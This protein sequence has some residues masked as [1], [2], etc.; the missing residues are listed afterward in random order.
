VRKYNLKRI[1]KELKISDIKEIEKML[2][3]KESTIR[4]R[5]RNA[6]FWLIT[7]PGTG[8]FLF[9]LG[10]WFASLNF[11]DVAAVTIYVSY[12]FLGF[13]LGFILM[14]PISRIEN[15]FKNNKT[16]I[17]IAY[18]LVTKILYI[19]VPIMIITLLF[20]L[21]PGEGAKSIRDAI[22][23]NYDYMTPVLI[24][25]AIASGTISLAIFVKWGILAV[26]RDFRYFL[27]QAA[28]ALSIEK[29][30]NDRERIK[31]AIFGI[32]CY[33]KYLSRH[34][35]LQIKNPVLIFQKIFSDKRTIEESLKEIQNNLDEG[36]L[37]LLKY[38]KEHAVTNEDTKYLVKITLRQRL[39]DASPVIAVI[40][41]LVAFVT[42]IAITVIGGID[43]P[44]NIIDAVEKLT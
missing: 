14:P 23:Q 42:Q 20:F 10:N 9:I 6:V 29:N 22:Q 39:V 26:Q 28:I 15:F 30:V 27:S 7:M 24:A 25:L 12:I 18:Q 43:D 11:P 31:Y 5:Q 37:S 35:D 34:F 38:L 33:N 44:T 41:S 4:D 13:P 19:S 1:E 3:S 21:L 16:A 8:V 17:V 2:Y 32:N 40:A 36:K